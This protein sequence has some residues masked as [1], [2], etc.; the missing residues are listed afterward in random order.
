MTFYKTTL[1]VFL[2]LFLV[3]TSLF[4]NHT[5]SPLV[6]ET[7]KQ[8]NAF[9]ADYNE[10]RTLT[11]NEGFT[12]NSVFCIF[13]DAAGFIW[14]GSWDGVYRYDGSHLKHIYDTS[15][16][17]GKFR[18]SIK[19]FL[20]DDEHRLWIASTSGIVLW[21]AHAEEL[22]PFADIVDKGALPEKV[23]RSFSKDTDGN[24]W[25]LTTSNLYLYNQKDRSLKKLSNILKGNNGRFNEIYVDK[26]NN[27]WLTSNGLG[28]LKM[29]RAL[30]ADSVQA[31]GWKLVTE[32]IFKYFKNKNVRCL[33]QDSYSNYWVGI[34]RGVFRVEADKT[35]Q[36]QTM[37]PVIESFLPK[38]TTSIR[39]NSMA[40]G[41]GCFYASTNN[42]LFVYSLEHSQY[43]WLEPNY[44]DSGSLPDKSLKQILVDREGGLW[45]GSFY[46][47]VSYL[48]PTAGNFS[49]YMNVNKFLGGH[50]VSGVAEDGDGNIW[51][52]VEDG[53]VSCWNRSDNTG[54]KFTR[55]SPTFYNP[56]KIN[57]QSIYA[58]GEYV[59]VGMFGGGMDIID[60][61]KKTS[62]HLT[63]ANTHPDALS[64]SIYSF[65]RIS[66][67]YL[68][69]GGLYGLYYLD[70]ERKEC[71]QVP[72]IKGKVNCII[73][74]SMGDYWVSTISEGVYQY[75]TKRKNWRH[76][77]HV[78]GD[79]TT[80]AT[81]E[82]NTLLAV[83]SS[84]YFGT[85]GKG[86]WEYNRMTKKFCPV[87]PEI[88]GEA[89][90]FK[91]LLA[92]DY[93][94]ITTNHGLYSYNRVTK[95]IQ[96]FTSKDGLRSDLFKEN[97]GIITSDGLY[98]VGGVNGINCFRP[99]QLR[100][101]LRKPQVILTGLSLFNKAVD[102]QTEDSP[103]EKS[104]TFS[105]CLEINQRHNNI[106]FHFSSSSHNEP[107]KNQ[108][109]YKLEPFDKSWQKT[110][111]I[112][113]KAS[114]ANLPAGKYVFRVRTNNGIGDWSDEK[115]LNLIVHPYWWRS[116]PMKII[117][118]LLLF[119]IVL[120]NIRRFQ[121]KKKEEMRL[122]QF[123]KEQEMYRSKMEFFTCVV[124]EIRTPLTLILGP[125]T[126]IM[127]KSGSIEDVKPELRIIERNGNRLM[128]LV[129]HLMD[130]RK[131]EEKSYTVQLS[132]IN[133]VDLVKQI[134]SEFKLYNIQ[135]SVDFIYKL[136]ATP[137]WG[138][139]DRD[140]FTKIL[141]N[142]L[143]NAMKFTK[144]K[145]EVGI[146]AVEGGKFWNVYVRDNGCGI[147]QKEQ[148]SIFD[149]FY[150]VHQNMPS[151]Y[152]GSG[153]G[154][155][156]VRRL[157]EL[158]GGSISLESRLN[159]GTCFKAKVQRVAP[160][161]VVEVPGE[162]KSPQ[163]NEQEEQQTYS[164]KKRLL[165]V[166][167]NEE[168]RN[169]IASVIADK[170]QVDTCENGKVALE[171]V[172]KQEYDLVITDLMMPVMDGITLCKKMKTDAM[173]SHIPIIILTA[174]DDETSQKEGFDSEADLYV[175]KPFS[176]E[177]LVSQVRAVIHNR[178]R[179][180]K[181]FYSEPES[182]TE[183]LCNNNADKI[184]LQ[185]LEN[186]ILQNLE[187]CNLSV[188]TLASAMALGRSVFYQKVK[189]VS[190]L[191]PNEYIRTFRL[192]KAAALF[193]N[194]ENRINEVCY[195]VG[196]SSPSYF[197]KRFTMQF[198][199][200]PSDYLKK[201]Q[202]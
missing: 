64:N 51:F 182:T 16:T 200:S 126:N 193:Q 107:N 73:K 79:S 61:K 91:I 145:I 72:G 187:D 148:T 191:T 166:E 185:N 112:N 5:V 65:Y 124:H 195:R 71:H 92:G 156:V 30:P 180:R 108:Y 122:F 93:F 134:T 163:E 46:G 3:V 21:D 201:C 53:G 19:G 60:L 130:F 95:Q 97:S 63:S 85:Q 32:P 28:I 47:G 75:E 113:N 194:G 62:H 147:A 99:S 114:Y 138:N 170:Y 190:G 103:L 150:Q 52:G 37:Q 202:R 78:E 22:M 106:T 12:R 7:I 165:V 9:L 4:A 173:T 20:E 17:D 111:Q 167:D 132:H 151:D 197:A 120:L 45:I 70:F 74:D 36:L 26:K 33:Y 15:H 83:N 135:K 160:P 31:E 174:K 44:L 164:E 121:S 24:I 94:W 101:S 76:L 118:F 115:Q 18:S 6:G 100:S 168:M 109:E 59:Y 192:K 42:G 161:E 155:F 49:K 35:E 186:L 184:F 157:L 81:D 14:F 104:I 177:V 128:S 89:L 137:C 77:K 172:A 1:T 69:V 55:T 67:R 23:V 80:I 2:S 82:I 39:V 143:S 181:Q 50:V 125:L 179:Q 96:R 119:G 117:Y 196:F 13:Q 105:D 41:D 183:V 127:K 10:F 136:P 86:I 88:L 116:I 176:S 48:A 58:D 87:A 149:S 198:G 188:D 54:T 175:T 140:A 153:V 56:S 27:I 133:L 25:I 171:Y 131:V 154:L 57:V 158:Q 162:P 110:V 178:E 129:N 90:I 29:E 189:G 159:E 66:R 11:V 144:D 199:I 8:E 123:E 146:E 102:M 40:E 141:A 84:V 142:L 34:N 139:I 68:L 43:R 169:Y 98:I 152:I 38:N